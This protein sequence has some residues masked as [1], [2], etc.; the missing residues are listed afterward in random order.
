MTMRRRA[1]LSGCA[2]AGLAAVAGCLGTTYDVKEDLSREYDLDGVST[3]AFDGVNGDIDFR[4]EQRE[5]VSVVG[6]KEAADEDGLDDI[7]LEANRDGDALLLTVDSDV[8]LLSLDTPPRIEATVT[9]P[10]SLSVN[11]ET[12]NGDV[13][14][15]LDEPGEVTA[16]TTNGNVEL[17]LTDPDSVTAQTTNGD[18]EVELPES[19][20]PDVDLETTNGE[21]SLDGFDAWSVDDGSSVEA[22]IGDGTVS[23]DLETT[24][25][26]LS[27]RRG[28]A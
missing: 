12:T 15:D 20:E 24:N 4:D 22:T 11:A 14:A 26:D 28:S 1:F 25:G 13:S 17:E 6:E 10:A 2:A 16:A 23:V 5:T 27:L 8:D 19:A 21:A 9:V 18:V 3:V 7:T